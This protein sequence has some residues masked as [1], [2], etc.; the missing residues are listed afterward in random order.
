MSKLKRMSDNTRRVTQDNLYQRLPYKVAWL[1]QYV[2]EDRGLGQLEAIVLIYKSKMYAQ[3][4]AEA[5]KLWWEGPVQLYERLCD[6]MGWPRPDGR[7]YTPE[8]VA[9]AEEC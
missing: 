3:L 7:V 5:T 9:A 4:A 8:D 1:T 6:E 2:M